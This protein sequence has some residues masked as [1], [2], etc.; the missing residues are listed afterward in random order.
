[1]HAHVVWM[2]AIPKYLNIHNF[3]FLIFAIVLIAG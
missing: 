2:G 3:K 1:M